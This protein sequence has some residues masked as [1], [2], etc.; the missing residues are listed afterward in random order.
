MYKFTS[1]KFILAGISFLT[2]LLTRA[3]SVELPK[4]LELALI[5]VVV[6]WIG[7]ESYIDSK[8][9]YVDDLPEEEIDITQ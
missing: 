7:G 9:V 8:A 5:S 1:R 2:V 4:E 3:F 6:I